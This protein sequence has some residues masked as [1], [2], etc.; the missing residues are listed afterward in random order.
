MGTRGT[1]PVRAA[2]RYV[3]LR[4]G[5]WLIVFTA[6]SAVLAFT[7]WRSDSPFAYQ[8]DVFGAIVV[9]FLLCCGYGVIYIGTRSEIMAALAILGVIAGVAAIIIWLILWTGPSGESAQSFYGFWCLTL[10]IAPLTLL[11]LLATV[12][13]SFCEK[14][15]KDARPGCCLKCGYL[16]TGLR[17]ARCPECGT[18]FDP[19]LLTRSNTCQ[20]NRG[21][22]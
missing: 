16:L 12:I 19:S 4:L 22:Q 17:D 20:T 6:V 3:C 2:R 14:P 11:I 1:R 5:R 21:D 13:L 10:C 9:P 18:R 8:L 7:L 15:A